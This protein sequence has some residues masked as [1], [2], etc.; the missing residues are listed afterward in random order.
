VGLDLGLCLQ[1]HTKW[2][3]YFSALIGVYKD[4]NTPLRG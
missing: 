3:G 4:E 1:E 2:V